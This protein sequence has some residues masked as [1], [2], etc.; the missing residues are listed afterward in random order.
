[1]KKLSFLLSVVALLLPAVAPA[2]DLPM[3][4]PVPFIVGESGAGWYKGLGTFMEANSSETVV[5]STNTF[6]GALNVVV[7]YQW[8]VSPTGNWIACE[9]SGAYHNVGGSNIVGS[10][11]ARW[12]SDQGCKFGGP[13]ANVLQ[14]LPAGAS[15]PTVPGIGSAIG[16]A[17]PWV[18]VFNHV[19]DAHANIVGVS[20]RNIVDKVTVGAG[21]IQKFCTSPT[22]C[23]SADTYFKYS[24]K[25]DGFTVLGTQQNLGN[26]YRVGINFVF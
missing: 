17:H 4:A 15:F 14:W 26:Q 21:L 18:G 10:V 5:G 1:M 7:G 25:Q 13:I 24:P 11:T 6:G 19:E 12:S 22:S 16:S 2:A 20:K 8:K 9:I 3:K 23:I